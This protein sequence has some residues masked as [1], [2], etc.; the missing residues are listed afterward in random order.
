M[1][2]LYKAS[3]AAE[4]AAYAAGTHLQASRSRLAATMFTHEE[5]REVVHAIDLE[6]QG[7]IRDVVLRQFPQHGFVCE[8]GVADWQA[9]LG[10]TRPVWIVD[11]LNGL[12]NYQRGYPQYAVSIALVQAGEPLLGVI[13]D[14]CRN[15]FFGAIH[16]QGAVLNG[17]PIR[18]ARPRPPIESLAATVFPKPSSACMPGYVAEFGRVVRGFGGVRRSGSMA[19]ELAYLSAARIDAFWEH[20]VAGWEYAAGILLVRES[21]A[22]IHSRDA[23]P[24]LSS[25]S[26]LACTPHLFEPL[27]SLLVED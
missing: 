12:V 19:L 13:Y 10:E 15:E 14:P 1:I 20:E 27:L 16:G 7:L 17:Q 18:C 9:T 5:P 24:P 4:Q 25:N 6:A 22:L 23:R 8:R 21:G 11:P 26:L 2:D 3:R